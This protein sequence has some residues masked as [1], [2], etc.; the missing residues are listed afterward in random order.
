MDVP[1]YAMDMMEGII[2]GTRN[3]SLLVEVEG[4]EYE[5][6][7]PSSNSDSKQNSKQ[8]SKQ[9]SKQEDVIHLNAGGIQQLLDKGIVNIPCLL[10]K[11]SDNYTIRA[12]SFQNRADGNKNWVGVDTAIL[13]D[14]VEYFLKNQVLLGSLTSSYDSLH[15]EVVRDA[16]LGNLDMDFRVGNNYIKVKAP[17]SELVL[18]N[19]TITVRPVFAYTEDEF[20][21]QTEKICEQLKEYD[22]TAI[23][24]VYQ[25]GEMNIFKA[26][27]YV[28][29]WNESIVGV[30]DKAYRNSL[31][32]CEI[33]MRID[34]AGICLLWSRN[35]ADK[36]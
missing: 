20:K 17:E 35:I 33:S 19:G 15:A 10:T 25:T 23:A 26:A 24:A 5:S 6:K 9:D 21:E 29:P 1:I 16:K 30:L 13:K 3:E 36:I 34:E 27:Q 8:N 4:S 7:W 2:V 22:S 18:D 32:I 12:V 28:V 14:V 11:D 31:E